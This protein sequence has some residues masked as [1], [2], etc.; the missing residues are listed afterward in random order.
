MFQRKVISLSAVALGHCR[1]SLVRSGEPELLK[2]VFLGLDLLDALLWDHGLDHIELDE[3]LIEVIQVNIGLDVRLERR[4]NL[5]FRH[6]L[7]VNILEKGMSEDVLNIVLLPQTVLAVL[8]QQLEVNLFNI[9]LTPVMR[10]L[11]SSETE[12]P[13]FSLSGQRMGACWMK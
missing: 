7:S 3:L 12:R 10:L 13:C 11:A 4:L 6:L 1:G 8:F 5:L 2:G 9:G